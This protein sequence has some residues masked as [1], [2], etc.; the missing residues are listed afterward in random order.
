MRLEDASFREI[1]T[2]YREL[3]AQGRV[4][5]AN[6]SVK[7]RQTVLTRA[8]DMRYVGQEHAVTVEIPLAVFARRDH[9]AIKRLFDA[10][11]ELRYGTS[12][13]AE[14]AEIVS[15]R[16]TVSGIMRKPA[17]PKIARGRSAPPRA[18][19][20]GARKVYF[21]GFRATEVYRRAELLSGNRIKGPAL[22]EEYA[23]TTLLMPGDALGVDDYGNLDIIVGGAR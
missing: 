18:A 19:F 22:I 17:Q 8:T 3:E 16:S 13:P 10:M 11:H 6:T 12:A 2:I 15:L 4:A 21:G 20:A 5:I 1:E 9:D 7:P 23:S 14:R